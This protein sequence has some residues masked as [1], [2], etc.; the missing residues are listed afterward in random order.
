P[1]VQSGDLTALISV[2]LSPIATTQPVVSIVCPETFWISS[3]SSLV[4]RG[5]AEASSVITTLLA[6]PVAVE[7]HDESSNAA[8][9]HVVPEASLVGTCQRTF[10]P[11]TISSSVLGSVSTPYDT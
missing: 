8:V 10:A 7:V 6:G 9:V 1:S 4:A 11:A 5:L 2:T 3:Q